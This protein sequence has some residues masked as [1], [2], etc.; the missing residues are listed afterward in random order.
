[1][2]HESL[3]ITSARTSWPLSGPLVSRP[4]STFKSTSSVSRLRQACERI[5]NTSR[6]S[7]DIVPT[8]CGVAMFC[9]TIPSGEICG[10]WFASSLKKNSMS[11]GAR[12]VPRAIAGLRL[13]NDPAATPRTTTS[14]G[15]MVQR[16]TSISL[17]SSSSPPL[18]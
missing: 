16:R 9:P 4:N 13:T 15:I 12:I 8:S 5:S 10:S 11:R 1:M 17:S 7:S 2:R 14:S 18:T 3:S 6:A